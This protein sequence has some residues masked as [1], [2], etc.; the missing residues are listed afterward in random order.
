MT[1]FFINRCKNTLRFGAAAALWFVAGP[2]CV[3]STASQDDAANEQVVVIPATSG[4]AQ[5]ALTGVTDDFGR[6]VASGELTYAG[7]DQEG[8][9]S[10]T[11]VAVVR[12]EDGDMIVADLT[13]EPQAD[14]STAFTFH[15]R[16]SVTFSDGTVVATDGRFVQTRPPG[17]VR[18]YR[19]DQCCTRVCALPPF[20][21]DCRYVCIPCNCRYVEVSGTRSPPGGGF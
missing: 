13:A 1:R 12:A 5:L 19:C 14:G 2:T 9:Q 17:L 21:G 8:A 18:I 15:W 20:D 16:D 6:Y 3:P 11:G 10:G 4:P 7:G